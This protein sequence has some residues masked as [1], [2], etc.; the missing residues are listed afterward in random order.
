MTFPLRTRITAL[1]FAVL[2][3]SFLSF[4]WISDFAFRNSIETTVN[5]AAKSNLD[6]VRGVLLRVSSKGSSEVED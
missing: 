4:A 3:V 6:S 5:D 2:V 1:Y